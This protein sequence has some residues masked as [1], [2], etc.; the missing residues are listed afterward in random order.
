MVGTIDEA[1]EKAE[2]LSVTQKFD[3]MTAKKED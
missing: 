2:T 1:L 3:I